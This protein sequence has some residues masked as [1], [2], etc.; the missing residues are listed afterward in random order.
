[1]RVGLFGFDTNNLGDEMQSLAVMSHLSVVDT[2]VDRDRLADFQANEDTTIVF[3]SWFMQ[4]TDFRIPSPRVK[5]MWHG[6]SAGRTELL[7]G[8][9]GDYLRANAPIGCR[10]MDSCKMLQAAGIDAYWTACL[11][12]FMGRALSRPPGPPS[13]VIFLDVP[14]EAET[15]IP[16]PI[17][18]RATRL[19]TFPGEHGMHDT[20]GRWSNTARLVQMLANA[21]LVVTRR[22]HAAL[23]AASF[24]VPVVAVPD[25]KHADARFRYSGIDQIIPT[26]YL[27]DVA[28]GLKNLDWGNI[29]LAKIPDDVEQRYQ[30]FCDCLKARGTYRPTG[31]STHLLDRV[32]VQS[33]KLD[34]ARKFYGTGEIRLR[35]GCQTFDLPVLLW[36]DKYVLVSIPTFPGISKL[37]LRVESTV[38]KG[39]DWHDEGLLSDLAKLTR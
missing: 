2:F 26:V 3:N 36:T 17:V 34:I 24:G 4:G 8:E 38:W 12:L 25:P 33:I 7:D 32:G 13:G 19:T 39:K 27:D 16:K 9:W 30:Q 1:M 37:R 22:L 29:P 15:Y 14:P 31:N 35:L 18:D 28:I 23:P 10:D 5:P 11:T 6:F 21:D 20:L